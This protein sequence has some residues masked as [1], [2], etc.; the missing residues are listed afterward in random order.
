MRSTLHSCLRIACFA[1]SLALVGTIGAW[2]PSAHAQEPSLEDG[3]YDDPEYGWSVEFDEELFQ[4][5]P[6]DGDD[7]RGLNLQYLPETGWAGFN[8]LLVFD[9][10]IDDPAECL[11]AR[12]DDFSGSSAFEDFEEEIRED[13]PQTVDDAEGQLFSA[14][15]M[16]D[17]TDIFY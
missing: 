6:A 14:T 4:G 2:L 9:D 3:R 17:E 10:G 1:V 12:V 11:E 13:P 15:L 8:N 7:Y 16:P 5:S